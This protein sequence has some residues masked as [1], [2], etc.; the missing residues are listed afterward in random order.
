MNLSKIKHFISEIR[1][2][3]VITIA[4]GVDEYGKMF[5]TNFTKR[6]PRYFFLK[7]KILG[8]ALIELQRFKSGSEYLKTV[9]GKNSAAYFSRK[10][11]KLGF[12]FKTFQPNEYIEQIHAINTSATIR[13]G[14]EMEESY[15][16]KIKTFPVDQ[17]N[18]Y[19]GIFKDDL[20]VAYLWTINS[21]EL[22][23]I[24][25]ILGH[26][27]HMEGGIMYLLVTSYVERLISTDLKP[28]VLMYDTLLGA[29]PG[30]KM[31]KHRCGFKSY[32][33]NWQIKK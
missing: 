18:T 19:V 2:L 26:A 25:R 31:F 5:Y 13:Q 11:A 7:N 23:L 15:K 12:V 6:H 33:V 10:A 21:Q 30:L 29:S 32:K 27:E 8:V 9:N 24:N 16:N 28:K 4:L 17:H 22:V 20:L 1:H 14:K 3:P